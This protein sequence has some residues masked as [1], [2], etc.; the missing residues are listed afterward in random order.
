MFQVI[1]GLFGAF[2][3][4]FIFDNLVSL[5][6]RAGHR[7]KRTQIWVSWG[8]FDCQD[9]KV[10]LRSFGTLLKF[11]IFSKLVSLKWLVTGQTDQDFR[12]SLVYTGYFLPL[13]VQTQS[14]V[15][16]CISDFNS[17]CVYTAELLKFRGVG[18]R[19]Q[20]I[21]FLETSTWIHTN[22]MGSYLSNISPFFS[23]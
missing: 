2:P 14:E 1:L 17:A 23:F 19:R 12:L 5:K 18:V 7:A 13:N 6:R 3:I 21:S 4:F 15:I 10:S 20:F 11:P 16:Q 9:F 8:T 22:F